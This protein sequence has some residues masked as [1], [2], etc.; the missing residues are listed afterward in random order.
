MTSFLTRS[1]SKFLPISSR[2][3]PVQIQKGM[4]IQRG[5]RYAH[6]AF[7]SKQ[8]FFVE[9][10]STQQVGVLTEIMQ[11]PTQ[12]PQCFGRAVDPPRQRMAMVFFGFDDGESHEIKRSVRVP[13][14]KGPFDSHQEDTIKLICAISAFAMQPRNVACHG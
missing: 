9:F 13:S 10:V 12:P 5:V 8:G 14:I 3:E 6:N 2:S 1:R 4:T 11:E 7:Q